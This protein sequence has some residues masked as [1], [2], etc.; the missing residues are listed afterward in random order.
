MSL[1]LHLYSNF[2][3][4]VLPTIS[5][6]EEVYR[7]DQIKEFEEVSQAYIDWLTELLEKGERIY[8]RSPIALKIIK[9]A[10]HL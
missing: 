1:R 9:K 5:E 6:E 10:A 8:S 7:I 3:H 2:Y 4:I